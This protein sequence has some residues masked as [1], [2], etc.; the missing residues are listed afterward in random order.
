LVRVRCPLITFK[1]AF[2]LYLTK[3]FVVYIID[4]NPFCLHLLWAALWLDVNN[5][6]YFCKL[7]F[8]GLLT[9]AVH[10]LYFQKRDG[11]TWTIELSNRF[12]W[13]YKTPPNSLN[14]YLLI[15]F[16]GIFISL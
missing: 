4:C 8:R 11:I 14:F 7:A 10:R 3:M 5:Y 16:I 12:P 2:N 9:T 13:E 6:D 1:S 15:L